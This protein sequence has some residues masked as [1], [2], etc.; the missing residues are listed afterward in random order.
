MAIPKFI[1]VGQK[2]TF[3]T[4]HIVSYIHSGN[5]LEITTVGE[6]ITAVYFENST[7]AKA[8]Y[9]KL[10]KLLGAVNL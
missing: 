2:R 3:N 5:Q 6:Y 10:D 9:E 4:A 7:A 8:A 1:S